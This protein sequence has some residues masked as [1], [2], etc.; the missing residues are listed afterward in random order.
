LVFDYF[1]IGPHIFLLAVDDKQGTYLDDEKDFVTAPNKT[2]TYD[3]DEDSNSNESLGDNPIQ[4]PSEDLITYTADQLFALKEV[5][6]SNKWPS[7][8][9][10]AFKNNRGH[11][12]PD[13]WHQNKKRGSTPPPEEKS[14]AAKEDVTVSKVSIFK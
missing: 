3:S 2:Y 6:L 8:L 10:E 11:W 14:A 12:D 7:Y 9:D 5:T 13:R 1:W 4:K